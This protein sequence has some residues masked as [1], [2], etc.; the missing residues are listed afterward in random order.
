VV[1]PGYSVDTG[2]SAAT[3]HARPEPRK[4]G[5]VAES[6]ISA[7]SIRWAMLANVPREMLGQDRCSVSGSWYAANVT[8]PARRNLDPL[9]YK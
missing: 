7:A 2:A 5:F 1:E 9:G 3:P 8:K 4:V 6:A